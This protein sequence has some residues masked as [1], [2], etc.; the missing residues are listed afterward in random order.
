[1]GG[2]RTVQRSDNR[3]RAM[4]YALIT[5]WQERQRFLPAVL[6]VGFSALLITLQGGLLLGLLTLMSTPV[7][8]ASA[9]VW[10]G[11]PEVLSVDLGRPIPEAWQ[12]RLA[13]QPEIRRVDPCVQGFAFW[14]RPRDN[15]VETCMVIGARL[16]ADS[17]GA[18]RELKERPGLRGRL[19]QPRA[20]AVD[21]SELERLGLAPHRPGQTASI[22]GHQVRVVGLVRGLKSLGGAYVFCSVETARLLLRET[23]DQTTYLLGRCARPG[24]AGRVVRRLRRYRNMSAFTAAAFSARSRLHWLFKTKAGL[25]LGFAAVLGLL[26]G[27]V[28]TA[29]TLYAATAASLREYA[30]LQA[31]GIP[32]WRIKG[33]VVMQSFWVGAAGIGLALPLSWLLAGVANWAGTRVLLEPWLVGGAAALTLAM[34]LLSGLAALR[35]LRLLEPA[36]LL[37]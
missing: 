7:D 6:A 13:I 24:H 3:A 34:A 35:S 23:P 2:D 33:A 11:H 9:D 30:V 14:L 4:N 17:L 18:V 22:N 19:A 1:M 15:G 8:H 12:A 32:R 29:Q 20:V 21:E 10:V 28:V 5:I 37:R 27:A 26:V 36:Q 25:A 16:D 31:Q